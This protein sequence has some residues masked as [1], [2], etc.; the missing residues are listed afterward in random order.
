MDARKHF[1]VA[2]LSLAVFLAAVHAGKYSLMTTLIDEYGYN[3]AK[4]KTN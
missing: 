1:L 4:F 3:I 2:L